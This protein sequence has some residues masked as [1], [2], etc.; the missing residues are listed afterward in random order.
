MG[1]L[2]RFYYRDKERDFLGLLGVFEGAMF[3]GCLALCRI[4]GKVG[5]RVLVV[6]RICMFIVEVFEG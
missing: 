1:S 2:F 4:R 3:V 6:L 5:S